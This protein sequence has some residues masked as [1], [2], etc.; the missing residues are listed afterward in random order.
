VRRFASAAGNGDRIGGNAIECG[1]VGAKVVVE[2]EGKGFVD[3]DAAGKNLSVDEGPED[4][5]GGAFVFLP[6]ANI[7]GIADEFADAAFFE[8]RRNENGLAITGNDESKK[9]LTE[10]P[11][12]AGEVVEIRARTEEEGV[13]FRVERGHE[14][15][16]VEEA[17]EEFFGSDGMDAI[18]ER[19]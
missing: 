9:A 6:D 1:S 18:A 4:E 2:G 14:F 19:F 3:A 16:S 5:L 15:M 10:P 12:N 8:G 17:G 13:E 11:A 7:E